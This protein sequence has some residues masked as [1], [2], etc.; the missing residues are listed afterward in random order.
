MGWEQHRYAIER[1]RD[2]RRKAADAINDHCM[3]CGRKVPE[4]VGYR[5]ACPGGVPTHA[6]VTLQ[7]EANS[8]DAELLD[9]VADFLLSLDG[10]K[11]G[12]RLDDPGTAFIA[13]WNQTIGHISNF[14]A[15]WDLPK[16]DMIFHQKWQSHMSAVAGMRIGSPLIYAGVRVRFGSLQS[17]DVLRT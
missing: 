2:M 16:P 1:A 5:C 6:G 15:I 17:M 8:S 13:D 12:Q 3:K 9:D 4:M 11:A 14:C 10:S 7:G